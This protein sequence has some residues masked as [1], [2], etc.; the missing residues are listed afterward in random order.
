MTDFAAIDF[1]TANYNYSSVCAVGIVIVRNSEVSETIYRLI[2]PC[3]NFY[4]Q[5]FTDDIHGISASDTDGVSPFPDVWTEIA[6]R[7][8][9][10]PLVAHNS[11]FD[12]DCLRAVHRIYNM[13]YPNYKFHCTCNASRR[14][15]GNALPNHQLQTVSA[16]CGY[17]LKNH[18]HALADAEA[19]AHIALKIQNII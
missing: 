12:E 1:E 5:W 13:E 17:A 19:C 18:H 9:G 16:H 6:P 3:P 10:L 2:H 7:I 4:L 14:V 8:E 11:R 15:F